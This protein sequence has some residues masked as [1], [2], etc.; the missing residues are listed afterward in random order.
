MVTKAILTMLD[1]ICIEDY[2]EC[3]VDSKNDRRDEQARDLY[4]VLSSGQQDDFFEWV[5]A[6]YYYEAD[7]IREYTTE[8]QNFKNYF[9]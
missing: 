6:T 7:N 9:K 5:E 2:F 4:T 1:M 3:I 8:M